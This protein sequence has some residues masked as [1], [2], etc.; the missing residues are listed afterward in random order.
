MARSIAKRSAKILLKVLAYLVAFVFG[1]VALVLLALAI[2]PL[3]AFAVQQGLAYANRTLDGYTVAIERVDRLDPWGVNARGIVLFDAQHRQIVEIPWLLVRLEPFAL[4]K[5]TLALTRV[6][7]DGVRAQLYA[8]DAQAPEKEKAD[9]P[10]E[11]SQFTIRADRVRIRGAS[12]VTDWSGRRAR[13]S[14]Q[15][16]AAALAHHAGHLERRAGRPCRHRG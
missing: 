6:E 14:G 15:R 2:P 11:P 12:L 4:V 3:R 1:L 5:S 9:E 10:S 16:R 7:I 8:A 13:D